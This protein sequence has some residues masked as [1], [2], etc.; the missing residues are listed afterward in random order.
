MIMVILTRNGR[1]ANMNFVIHSTTKWNL[2][3][4]EKK[5]NITSI[6]FML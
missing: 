6:A 2:A 5:P 4:F 3:G 1:K